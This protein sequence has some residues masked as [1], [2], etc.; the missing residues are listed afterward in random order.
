MRAHFWTNEITTIF[1]VN[2]FQ[3]K[4][5]VSFNNSEVKNSTAETDVLRYFSWKTLQRVLKKVY[6]AT[7]F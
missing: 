4:P 1:Q 3:V 5:L 7:I 6:V 2:T